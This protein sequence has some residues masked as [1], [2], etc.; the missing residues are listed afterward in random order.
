MTS[1]I[2]SETA[3]REQ[4][5]SP[6][7]HFWHV[8]AFYVA[9]SP[10]LG[11]M[12]IWTRRAADEFVLPLFLRPEL[13]TTII[14]ALTF[15]YILSDHIGGPSLLL[16]TTAQRRWYMYI[17]FLRLACYAHKCSN[18]ARSGLDR[19][20]SQRQSHRIHLP[21]RSKWHA[22][23]I[24]LKRLACRRSRQLDLRWRRFGLAS[25]FIRLARSF[26]L[27]LLS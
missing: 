15:D 14:R 1:Y 2:C 20:T 23:Y 6:L 10:P 3:C 25:A 12:A 21:T 4:Q 26:F 7:N 5:M 8:P 24:D 18:T 13:L 19:S 11:S 22:A 16:P 9:I 17:S 27:S